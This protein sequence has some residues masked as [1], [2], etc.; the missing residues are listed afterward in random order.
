MNKPLL[1]LV[2]GGTLGILDGLTALV[3]APEVAPNIMAIV[4]GS[5]GKGLVAG[6][7]IG[8]VARK[9]HN[10]AIGLVVGLVVGALLALPIAMMKDPNTGQVYFWEILIPGSIVGLIVGFAT[11]RYGA[12]PREGGA[13]P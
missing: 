7:I 10:L 5:M 8:F 6:L 3:S 2:V 9:V 11:Q 12:L 13:R 1:G 4:I